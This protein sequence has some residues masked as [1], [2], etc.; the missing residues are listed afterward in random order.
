VT[1][2]HIL[3]TYAKS[4]GLKEDA[5]DCS[6]LSYNGRI[7]DLSST[8]WNEGMGSGAAVYWSMG[9]PDATDDSLAAMFAG[10][11]VA[12]FMDTTHTLDEFGVEE[13]PGAIYDY[14]GEKDDSAAAAHAYPGRGL[15]LTGP[16]SSTGF[17]ED[18][19]DE[20]DEDEL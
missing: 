14:Q 16:P 7:L 17:E 3:H 15:D 13:Q 1:F 10:S 12:G 8:P 11:H 4:H 9:L 5:L 20:D 2:R 19:D 18:D 6:T